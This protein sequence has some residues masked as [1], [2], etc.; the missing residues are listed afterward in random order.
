MSTM[1]ISEIE[2][3]VFEG[4]GVAGGVY[5][6]AIEKYMPEFLKDVEQIIEKIK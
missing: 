4:G 1:N 6:G 5:A 3:L 2:N